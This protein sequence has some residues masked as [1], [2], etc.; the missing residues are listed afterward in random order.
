MRSDILPI[1]DLGQ[2]ELAAWAQLGA[3]AVSPNPFAEPDFVLP[4]IHAWKL[5][6]VGVLVVSE[7]ADWLGA[8]PVLSVRSWRGVP[9]RCLVAWRHRY[10][11]LGTP[12]IA[13]VDPQATLSL[14]IRRGLQ[15]CGCL[16]LDVIDAGGPLA[17]PL[18]AALATE[19]RTFVLQT[20]KRAALYRR[21]D[22]DYLGLTTT[23]RHRGDLRRKFRLLEREVG[24][25]T[26]RDES[27][28][29]SAWKRFLE[30]ELSG[31]KGAG[32]TA[33][34]SRPQDARFFTDMCARFAGAG[35]LHLHSL[36]SSQ[37]TVAMRCDLVAG[38][39][40][41]AFKT[42][43]DEEF[44]RLSP[45]MQLEVANLDRFHA[46]GLAWSDSCA[47]PD[48][49]AIGKLWFG[50]RELQS[51]VATRRDV[52]G[53]LRLGK[54]RAGIGA[55]RIRGKLRAVRDHRRSRPRAG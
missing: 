11:F 40:S 46:S 37:R 41:Y 55:L 19:A 51:V 12:L 52:P 33:M 23:A 2:R 53:A 48:N 25:L 17:A 38:N 6:D 9:G 3:G 22:P 32:G 54:W 44:A 8:I 14:L 18:S 39:M 7:G 28:D 15:R 26:M 43:Y 29:P 42:T 34:A 49:P 4:A 24:E 47:E 36:S 10:C 16:A 30:L 1:S 5:S 31:W 27:D 50:R 45:G 20:F 21:D 13:D 35:R